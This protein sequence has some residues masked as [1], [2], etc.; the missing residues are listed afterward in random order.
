M[1]EYKNTLPEE[2][3]RM[4]EPDM[5]ELSR[6]YAT[7]ENSEIILTPQ[8]VECRWNEGI[9]NCSVYGKKLGDYLANLDTCPKLA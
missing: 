1:D 3:E 7:A 8:C 9:D 2:D 5:D 6:F 4:E